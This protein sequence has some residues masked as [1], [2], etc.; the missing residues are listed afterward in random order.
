M[1]RDIMGRYLIGCQ[2]LDVKALNLFLILEGPPIRYRTSA[3]SSTETLDRFTS[4]SV[5]PSK[6]CN[7]CCSLLSPVH[8]YFLFTRDARLIIISRNTVRSTYLLAV[9]RI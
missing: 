1:R 4:G 8:S 6:C 3:C 5:I 2:D 9:L 7:S